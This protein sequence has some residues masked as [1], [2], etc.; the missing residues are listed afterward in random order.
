MSLRSMLPISMQ[1]PASA[2]VGLSGVVDDGDR[3]NEAVGFF[4]ASE[5]DEAS[6]AD[7]CQPFV[8]ASGD[9]EGLLVDVECGRVG[10]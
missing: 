9:W 4:V 1:V 2:A 5:R 10:G 8:R 6:G 7:H 3:F